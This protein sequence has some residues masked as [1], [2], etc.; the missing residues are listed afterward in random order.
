MF[1]YNSQ[2]EKTDKPSLLKRFFSFL[3][4]VIIVILAAWA[5][6]TYV[7]EPFEIPSG[8]METT[9]EVGDKVFA[10]KIS[11]LFSS[12]EQGDIVVFSDP[13][14]P[15]RILIKRVIATAGQTVDLIDGVVYVDGVALNE[16]YTNGEPSYPLETAS[17]VSIS[18]PY[19]IPENMIWVMGDNRTDSSDS[20]YFGPIKI[21]SIVGKAFMT[22]WPLES[23]GL[24]E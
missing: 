1:V 20:R 19:T 22:Y 17:N 16:S 15:S 21:S 8:S 12:P 4:V 18:Y 7:I 9:I 24:L 13:Q 5:I 11:Y 3:V 23:I 6:R 14:V 2:H 10:E